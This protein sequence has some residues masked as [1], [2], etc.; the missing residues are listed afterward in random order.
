MF[1]DM[2]KDKRNR[3]AIGCLGFALAQVVLPLSCVTIVPGAQAGLFW[4]ALVPAAAGFVAI[5]WRIRGFAAA[6]M[7]AFVL[8][9]CYYH[10]EGWRHQERVRQIKSEMKSLAP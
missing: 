3:I 4:V 5:D 6:L 2:L 9:A 8:G 10:G 7:V 1:K